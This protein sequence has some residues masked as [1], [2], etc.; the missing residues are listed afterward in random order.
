MYTAGDC[1]LSYRLHQSAVIYQCLGLAGFAWVV[2][3]LKR[4]DK[5]QKFFWIILVV[6]A[7]V[8]SQWFWTYA[9]PVKNE[10]KK[11]EIIEKERMK[12]REEARKFFFSF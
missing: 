10:K 3:R 1:P 4:I 6:L 9:W 11:C 7:F 8:F 2:F 5:K 12:K